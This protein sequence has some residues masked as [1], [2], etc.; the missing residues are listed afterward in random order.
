MRK[1]TKAEIT[2]ALVRTEMLT[3][4][5]QIHRINKFQ[6]IENQMHYKK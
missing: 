4:G 2:L 6:I 3:D 1:K 5:K